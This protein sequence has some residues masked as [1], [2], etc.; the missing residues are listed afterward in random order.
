VKLKEGCPI[1][2]TCLERKNHR[3]EEAAEWESPVIDRQTT[4]KDL[5]AQHMKGKPKKIL[6]RVGSSKDE[7]YIY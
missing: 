6:T 1:P 3:S 5:L 7:P 4:Y 2:P